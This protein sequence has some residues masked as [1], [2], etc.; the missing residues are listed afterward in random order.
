MPETE[1]SPQ[2][3]NFIKLLATTLAMVALIGGFLLLPGPDDLRDQ[4]YMVPVGRFLKS[5]HAVEEIKTDRKFPEIT[6][7]SPEG[8]KVDL[9]KMAQGRVTIVNFW[10]TW[11]APC[12]EE[13]PSLAKFQTNNPDILMMPISLDMNKT[14][15]ELAK[16]FSVDELKELRWFYDEAGILRKDLNLSVYPSTYILNKEGNIIYILQGPSDWSSSDASGF[17]KYLL[18]KF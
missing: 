2:N 10:A 8:R 13:L 18:S 12:I 17:A 4:A 14:L 7:L 11:C 6:L 16:F 9:K 1:K 3:S 15:P 5:F